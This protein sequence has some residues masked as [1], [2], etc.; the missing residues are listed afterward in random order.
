MFAHCVT[1]CV[2]L[3]VFLSVVLEKFRGMFAYCM[4]NYDA[5]YVFECVFVTDPWYVCSLYDVLCE[6]LCVIF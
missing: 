5:L 2:R 4:R 6:F 1:F 3:R